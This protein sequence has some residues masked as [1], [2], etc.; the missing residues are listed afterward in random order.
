[1]EEEVILVPSRSN[2]PWVT[3]FVFPSAGCKLILRDSQV[4]FCSKQTLSGLLNRKSLGKNSCGRKGKSRIGQRASQA[5]K[6]T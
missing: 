5:M 4:G 2:L 3:F 1:M 6:Q